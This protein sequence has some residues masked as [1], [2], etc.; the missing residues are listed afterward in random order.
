MIQ[1]IYIYIYFFFFFFFFTK[2][3]RKIL[4]IYT[5]QLATLQHSL[6]V[7]STQFTIAL[8]ISDIKLDNV[9]KQLTTGFPILTVKVYDYFYNM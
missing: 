3:K 7:P 2:E 5:K 8:H 6:H 4:N 9:L 1:F